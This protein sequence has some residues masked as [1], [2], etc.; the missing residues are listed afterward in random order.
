MTRTGNPTHTLIR[1]I[2]AAAALAALVASGNAAMAQAEGSAPA[3]IARPA[4]ALEFLLGEWEG[5]G[6]A[7][8]PGGQRSEF[9][10]QEQITAQADGHGVS[11]QG[12]GWSDING[13]ERVVHNAFGL[14]WAGY[15]G[16]Y[17]MRSVVMQGHTAEAVAEIGNNTLRWAM[18]AGPMGEYRYTSTVENDVWHEVGERRM[19]GETDWTVFLEMTLERTAAP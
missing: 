5:T 10:V 6:W 11:L 4:D 17:H 12:M 14:L 2:G 15:D 18:S 1:L 13:E 9:R 19:P 3:G 8:G 16:Q 7:M